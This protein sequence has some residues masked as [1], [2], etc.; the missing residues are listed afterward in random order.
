MAHGRKIAL[1]E[2]RDAEPH[3]YLVI[4]CASTPATGAGCHHSG[5][6]SLIHALTLWGPDRHLDSC[7][8]S[9]PGAAL[10]RWMCERTIR[11]GPAASRFTSGALGNWRGAV[12]GRSCRI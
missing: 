7:H 11:E 8:S 3:S 5:Q 9:A 4:Y 6:M 1:G 12:S 10:G 2:A